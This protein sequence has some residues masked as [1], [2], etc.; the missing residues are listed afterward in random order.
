MRNTLLREKPLTPGNGMTT[1]WARSAYF[2]SPC[3]E[4]WMIAH[5]APVS[6]PGRST[7]R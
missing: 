4:S 6:E 2:F 1:T 5:T 3:T 7:G